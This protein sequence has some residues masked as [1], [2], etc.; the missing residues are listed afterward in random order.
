MK[1]GE[2]KKNTVE[3]KAEPYSVDDGAVRRCND[4]VIKRK[5]GRPKGSTKKKPETDIP[6]VERSPRRRRFPKG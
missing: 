5:R 1:V 3:I 6:A 2:N 4:P